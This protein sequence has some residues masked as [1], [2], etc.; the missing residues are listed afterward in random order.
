MFLVPDKHTLHSQPHNVRYTATN[1]LL[2]YTLD[3]FQLGKVCQYY[4]WTFG[5]KEF[6][7]KCLLLSLTFEILLYLLLTISSRTIF[8]MLQ[9]Q[10]A[11]FHHSNLYQSTTRELRRFLTPR[12]T[13]E[14]GY[15]PQVLTPFA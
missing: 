3:T 5:G 14:L 9:E 2:P 10:T 13:E 1:P 15:L 6:T 4:Y 12:C 11:F 7:L 8:L